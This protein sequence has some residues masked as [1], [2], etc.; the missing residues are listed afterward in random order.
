M[1]RYYQWRGEHLV[2][3]P[4]AQ[5]RPYTRAW[6]AARQQRAERRAALPLAEQSRDQ[7]GFIVKTTGQGT[8]MVDPG[9]IDRYL[10]TETADRDS[11]G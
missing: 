9:E 5:V 11:A 8:V 6:L 2:R 7:F 10:W 4:E 3:L 1:S